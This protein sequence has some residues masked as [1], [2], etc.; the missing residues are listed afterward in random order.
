LKK[1]LP[2]LIGLIIIPLHYSAWATTDLGTL[3]SPDVT[4]FQNSGPPG[5]NIAIIISNLPDTSK[6]VYPYPDLYIY[7][8]FSQ[9]FGTS[10]SSNCA[11][12]DCFPIYL[13]TDALN[14]DFAARIITFSLPSINNP[15]PIF[16]NGFENSVCDILVN[17]KTVERFSTLCNTKDQPQGTYQIKF[18]WALET[19]LKQTFIVKTIPFTV[20]PAITSPTTQVADNGNIILKEYQ[21]GT[22]N[23]DQFYSKLKAKG[24]N[25]EQIRQA[26]AVLGKLP[27][28]MGVVGP[29]SGLPISQLNSSSQSIENTTKQGSPKLD[30]KLDVNTT[31]GVKKEQNSQNKSIS[32]TQQNF[33]I[34]QSLQN[35]SISS[36]Q[37][38]FSAI[39]SPQNNSTWNSIII[40]LSIAAITMMA[41]VVI[42]VK[43]MKK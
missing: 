25:D 7:L 35:K 10:L 30:F 5:T 26:L 23:Q 39:Q 29:D 19:D 20:T 6:E 12:Q 24:W 37:Q 36:T 4:I 21:N 32:S 11:G 17:S 13:H 16:L 22:I 43:K 27:H 18:A 41:A 28:Q 8:P 31:G 33:S 9:S 2:V 38:N 14:H 42:I 15:K 34:T 1:L 40:G 3:G